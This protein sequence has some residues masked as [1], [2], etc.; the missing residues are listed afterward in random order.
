MSSVQSSPR[1]S[2]RQAI[3]ALLLSSAERV[4][5]L[6]PGAAWS[7]SRLGPARANADVLSKQWLKT[8]FLR[9]IETDGLRGGS[10]VLS[11][12]LFGA[13]ELDDLDHAQ[14]AELEHRMSR[15][16]LNPCGEIIGS[17][18]LCN[19]AEVHL[20]RLDPD[21]TES[22]DNAFRAAAITVATL[23][24]HR[25]RDERMRVARD[26]YPIVVVSF[27]GLFD[28]FVAQLGV[29]WLQW[30]AEGRPP[31]YQGQSFSAHETK[32]LRRFRQIV[33]AEVAA[34]CC[35]HSLKIPNRCTTVQPA[36]CL[37]L[38][39]LRATDMGL[40]LLDEARALIECKADPLTLRGGHEVP[41]VVLNEPGPALRLT[42]VSGRQITCTPDHRFTLKCR[43]TWVEASGLSVGDE[44]EANRRSPHT[45]KPVLNLPLNEEMGEL[46]KQPEQLSMAL[47]YVAGALLGKEATKITM[48]PLK[49]VSERCL[50]LAFPAT[51][52][53]VA[54]RV[55]GHVSDL[56]GLRLNR[57]LAG[58]TIHVY[59][60]Q[61]AL[62][63]WFEHNGLLL[64]QDGS[65]DRL[66]LALR[67]APTSSIRSFFSGLIDATAC[68]LRHQPPTIKIQDE[69][70][71]RHLQQVGEAVGLN[72][73]L[74]SVPDHKTPYWRLLLSRYW[75]DP[76][77]LDYLKLDALHCQRREMGPT[78]NCFGHRYF[79]I[80]SIEALEAPVATGDISIDTDDD[81][82]LYWTGAIKS[83]NSKSLLTNASPGWHPPKAPYYIRRITFAKDDPIA[84]A[85]LDYGY[86][87]V[88]SQ[89]DKDSSGQLLDDPQDPRCTEW[90][91]E[92]PTATPWASLDGAAEIDP[93]KLSA[94]AQFDFYMQVQQHYSGHNTS[95]TLELT[96][97]EIEPL[98]QSIHAAIHADQGYISAALLARFDDKETYPRMPFE[99]ITKEHYEEL[100]QQVKDRRVR[101]DFFEALSHWDAEVKG[102]A[103]Q[104][105]GPAGCDSDKCLM[106]EA[107]PNA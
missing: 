41:S 73:R 33:E 75:S 53:A 29:D 37:S 22:V 49:A 10:I 85:C 65:S 40:L 83:H 69:T 106:P 30:W 39:A 48:A 23:L 21:D 55:M 76:A 44:L 28:Y 38:E 24:R 8:S 13:S 18:F 93:G 56:F 77:A 47:A 27:T 104:V 68:K 16:G 9:A 84:L 86:T 79:A 63:A 4:M 52:E 88:P 3:S 31:H 80:A 61:A 90:L 26:F 99:P 20:N 58:R 70:L 67:Q 98:A 1:P 89:S 50:H 15:F 95:A 43:P 51:E 14:R 96:E 82:A 66:P 60:R 78:H 42:L 46:E 102:G 103:P 72:F 32:E 2:T 54:E 101:E 92:I 35:E 6:G 62:R 94:L 45:G 100:C 64:R 57:R 74:Q 105:E 59:T 97:A 71:A 11:V 107:K 7:V 87:V 81:N 34:Y 12:A 36:G 17:D 91:V 19:L 25:F 5:K